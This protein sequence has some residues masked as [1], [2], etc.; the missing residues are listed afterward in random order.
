MFMMQPLKQESS[1]GAEKKQEKLN[2]ISFIGK[3]KEAKGNVFTII[4]EKTIMKVQL[5]LSTELLDGDK[6]LDIAPDEAVQPGV[7]V[8][9][10]GLL[11]KRLNVIKAVRLYIFHK[12]F[13]MNYLGTN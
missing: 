2:P 6:T 13:D 7:T 5:D 10:V 1:D 11:N 9:I 3:V 8:Q 4:H 12:E